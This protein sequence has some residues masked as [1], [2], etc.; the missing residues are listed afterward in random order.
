MKTPKFNPQ[1]IDR[2]VEVFYNKDLV[3]TIFED[4]FREYNPSKFLPRLRGKTLEN[5]IDR[6]LEREDVQELH[7]TLEEEIRY[8]EEALHHQVANVIFS[9]IPLLPKTRGGELKTY[10]KPYQE[11][12]AICHDCDKKVATGLFDARIP[13]EGLVFKPEQTIYSN[14]L[15]GTFPNGSLACD[16]CG[17]E[18]FSHENY[19]REAFAFIVRDKVKDKEKELGRRVRSVIQKVANRQ[20]PE[21]KSEQ[22]KYEV[23]EERILNRFYHLFKTIKTGGHV[24]YSKLYKVFEYVRRENIDLGQLKWID[25]GTRAVLKEEIFKNIDLPYAV[26]RTR[27]KQRERRY[28][29]TLEVL[30][31]LRNKRKKGDDMPEPKFFIDLYG[32]RV[33]LPTEKD[34]YDLVSTLKKV[35]GFNVTHENDDI[36]KPKKSGYQA[37]QLGWDDGTVVYEIQI[38]THTMDRN[39]ETDPK[40]IHDT[41]YLD[42]KR[43]KLERIPYQVRAVVAAVWG[44]Y[45][46]TNTA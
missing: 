27:I 43:E 3:K 20:L 33:I 4:I 34:C 37:Y 9:H 25:N 18:N 21:I 45:K 32:I 44:V 36:K 46:P 8:G 24:N 11:I 14:N 30:Y 41:A 17:N 16:N 2:L 10:T 6:I 12:A 40:Q 31:N 1:H 5:V 38:K 19:H 39:A 7:S 26:I 23:M 29:K 22:K 28:E 42:E 15:I 35:S 13:L